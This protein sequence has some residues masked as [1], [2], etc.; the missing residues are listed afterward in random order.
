MYGS[1]NILPKSIHALCNRFCRQGNKLRS[2]Q[3]G[4]VTLPQY[5]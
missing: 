2:M 5:K 1:R 3:N 4:N